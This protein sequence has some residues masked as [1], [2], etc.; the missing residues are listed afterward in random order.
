ME[1]GDQNNEEHEVGELMDPQPRSLSL[2]LIVLVLSACARNPEVVTLET[3]PHSLYTHC[4]IEYMELDGGFWLANVD[5]RPLL[6]FETTMQ[7]ADPW[8]EGTLS[9]L[10]DGS[11]VYHGDLGLVMQFLPAPV[12]YQPPGCY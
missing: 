12:G 5:D 1:S 4:G 10:S 3:V 11:V 9:M 2:L 6:P 8:D 7:W